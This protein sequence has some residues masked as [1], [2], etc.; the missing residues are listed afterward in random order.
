MGGATGYL[1]DLVALEAVDEG[2]FPVDCSGTVSL[3]TMVIVT[4]CI[5]LD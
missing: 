3:L 4:P 5:Y 2:W 1:G